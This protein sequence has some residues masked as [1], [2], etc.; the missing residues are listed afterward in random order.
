MLD[1]TL[2]L[3]LNQARVLED[4]NCSNRVAIVMYSHEQSPG[5]ISIGAEICHGS[6]VIGFFFK[7][8]KHTATVIDVTW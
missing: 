3:S 1:L 2:G 4:R 6:E 5:T 8:A 7:P